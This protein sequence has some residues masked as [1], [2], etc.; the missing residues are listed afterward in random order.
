MLHSL[1]ISQKL[2][3]PKGPKYLYLGSTSPNQII[4][5]FP[6]VETLQA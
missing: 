3:L 1:A 2:S 4:V 5:V 6:T